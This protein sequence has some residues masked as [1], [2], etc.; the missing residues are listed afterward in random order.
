MRRRLV[1]G[2]TQ[3]PAHSLFLKGRAAPPR[4]VLTQ[5]L[6]PYIKTVR[7]RLVIGRTQDPAHSLLLRGPAV[8]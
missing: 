1:I 7:R 3:D 4:L 5:N 2:R 8:A 6:D